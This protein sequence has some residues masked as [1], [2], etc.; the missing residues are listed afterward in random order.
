MSTVQEHLAYLA[1]HGVARSNRFRVIIPIPMQLQK[2]S[3]SVAQNKTSSFFGEDVIKLIRSFAGSGVNEITRG[4]DVMVEQTEL[5]GK[6]L[7][8][9]DVKYN[10]DTFKLPYSVVYGVQQFTFHSSQDMYEKNLIDE[11]LGL[12]FDPITHEIAYMDDYVVDIFINQLDNHDEV[13][14]STVLRDAFPVSVNPLV[15]SNEEMNQAHRVMCQF[16]YRRWERVGEKENSNGLVD[17]LS[18]TPFGPYVTPILSNPVVQRGLDYLKD[19]GIDLE[20]EAVNIY[21]Q[22]DEIVRNTTGQ[23]VNQSVSLIKA[24]QASTE[25]ND[26]IPDQQ[27][28]RVLDVISGTLNRLTGD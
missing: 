5:P 17:A 7:T 14:Y 21:N 25:I 18:E 23:S 6:Q 16:A 24:I 19:Q 28:A 12:I 26:A 27:K 9:I 15:V 20:G 1:K 3:S 13:V 22:V 11:W 4:L 10:G 8:T 2:Q